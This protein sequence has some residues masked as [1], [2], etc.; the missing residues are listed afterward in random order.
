MSESSPTSVKRLGEVDLVR[1]R[2]EHAGDLV[3]EEVEQQLLAPFGGAASSILRIAWPSADEPSFLL[4][5]LREQEEP[6]R[7]DGCSAKVAPGIPV[8]PNHADL[9]RIV[10]QEPA[11]Q[12][13]R[14]SRR[15]ALQTLPLEPLADLLV[16]GHV[17][18]LAE[19][20]P[21]HRQGGQTERPSVVG[22]RVEERIRRGVGGLARKTEDGGHRREA[23][24]EIERHSQRLRVEVPAPRAR[25]FENGQQ[26]RSLEVGDERSL[27]GTS[28]RA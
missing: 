28:P 6:W 3:L 21:V 27:P 5:L 22:E 11:E 24:E 18:D 26:A 2:A 19:V 16:P 25:G 13:R 14:L 4:A 7:P 23:D 9:N 15:E 10:L 1:R 12:G 8:H 20:S 17:A